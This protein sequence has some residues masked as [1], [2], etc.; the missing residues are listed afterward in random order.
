M[1]TK[2]NR[3]Y[4]H[5]TATDNTK[6]RDNCQNRECRTQGGLSTGRRRLFTAP[7]KAGRGR[8]QP[9]ATTKMC[10]SAAWCTWC[11][12]PA[13][14]RNCREGCA[15][16]CQCARRPDVDVAVAAVQGVRLPWSARTN[17]LLSICCCGE[18]L[19][20][21]TDPQRF[22]KRNTHLFHFFWFL[23]FLIWKTHLD[24]NVTFS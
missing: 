3:I 20:N 8:Y 2:T 1:K 5:N 13:A 23:L 15:R 19:K 14:M 17:Q 16:T 22:F 24:E 18:Y 7:N 12:R 21:L 10:R 6:T 4:Q 11:P 9:A